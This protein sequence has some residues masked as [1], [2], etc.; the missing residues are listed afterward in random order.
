MM[1]N[2]T[3]QYCFLNG[4][5]PFGFESYN[6]MIWVYEPTGQ[7]AGTFHRGL[8]PAL[9][10]LVAS[11]CHPR[12]GDPMPHKKRLLSVASLIGEDAL[13]RYPLCPVDSSPMPFRTKQKQ[14]TPYS[15]GMS[16]F[17]LAESMGLEP[18]GL[19]HLTRFPGELL[20]HSVNSPNRFGTLS[21]LI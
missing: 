21:A 15:I 12:S 10:G 16:C 20:S 8:C 3:K 18:T 13:P 6:N 2:G 19:L 11:P 9:G 4:A 7:R 17:C 5:G 14:D 1:H